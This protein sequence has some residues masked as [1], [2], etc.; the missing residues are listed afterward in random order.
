MFVI[1]LVWGYMEVFSCTSVSQVVPVTKTYISIRHIVKK[2]ENLLRASI[3]NSDNTPL[4]QL[5]SVQGELEGDFF[6]V[7]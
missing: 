7:L 1:L 4:V 2:T 5:L 6:Y 3:E